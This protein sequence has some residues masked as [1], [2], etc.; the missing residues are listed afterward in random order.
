MQT[1]NFIS[2][3]CGS[4]KTTHAVGEMVAT[5]GHHILSCDRVNEFPARVAAIVAAAAALGRQI[6]I[7]EISASHGHS[8]HHELPAA[9]VRH[10]N[11]PH[12][13]L[14]CTHAAIKL[15]DH[16]N[17]EGWTLWIDEDPKLWS[18]GSLDIIT[19]DDWWSRHYNLT[20]VM[21]GYSRITLKADAPSQIDMVSDTLTSAIA[22]LHDRM[23]R[24]DVI[25]NIEDWSDLSK[26]RTARRLTWFTIWNVEELA[27]YDRVTIM[28]NAFD[29]L[30]TY[31]LIQA[32]C[33][34]VQL[35]RT[36]ISARQPWEPRRITFNYVATDHRATINFI[37]KSAEGQQ[38]AKAWEA[39]VSERVTPAQHYWCANSALDIQA[40]GQRVS[41][42]IAGSNQYSHLTQC[43]ILYAAKAS[44]AEGRVFADLTDGEIDH[45]AV[46]RDR[47]YE[48]LVQIVFRSSLR[49]PGDTRPVEVNV[50]DRDQ[51]EFLAN[52]FQ[53]SFPDFEIETRHHDIGVTRTM[54]KR[55]R[56]PLNGV[57]LTA[58]ERVRRSRDKAKG[59]LASACASIPVERGE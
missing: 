17:V 15:S 6:T 19:T 13:I 37:A 57:P 33:P 52:F 4:G 22:P 36:P 43:S 51:A 11:D 46:M 25:V 58:A 59:K 54:Q 8:V 29:R 16:R 12:V 53:K 27:G 1:I 26:S 18:S 9:M 23:R 21:Q 24:R 7:R 42:K 20:P 5:P 49:V 2:D 35:V 10:T 41:P 38:A 34:N 48:D 45:D 39:W 55:G 3:G 31:K 28:A 30:I 32:T 40:P 47:E 14:I 56:K 44:A 50:Y